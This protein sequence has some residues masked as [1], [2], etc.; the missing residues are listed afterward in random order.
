MTPYP[1]GTEAFRQHIGFGDGAN[2][3][4]FSRFR[5]SNPVSL[6]NSQSQYDD[7]TTDMW[8]HATTT[9]GATVHLPDQ[10][11]VRLSTDTTPGASVIRQTQRYVRYQPGKSQLV[12]VTFDNEAVDGGTKRA[13]Y[14]DGENGIFIEMDATGGISFNRRS[15][16]T[17]SVVTDSVSQADWNVDGFGHANNDKNPSGIT[18]SNIKSQIFIIDLQWLAVGRVRV[19]VDI[20]G[21]VLYGH[22]FNWAN[23]NNGVYMTTANLPIRYELIGNGNNTTFMAICCSVSSEGGFVADLGHEHVTPNGTTGV[24][25]GT[26]S[27]TFLLAIRPK[28]LVNSI[29][30][31]GEYVPEGISFYTTNNACIYRLW[32]GG[33][34]TGGAW[35]SSDDESGLEYNVGATISTAGHLTNSDF[36]AAAGGGKAFSTAGRGQASNR[37]FLNLDIDGTQP[38]HSNFYVTGQGLGGTASAFCNIHWTEIK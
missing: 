25:C 22:N 34:L 8:N 17:G 6:L 13:G 10:S 30:N 5:V 24:S 2:F 15:K 27:D 11:S 20:D 12:F 19:G 23:E 18:L 9:G 31:R 38:D 3:D 33:T 36:G 37:I 16:A 4:A 26:G 7:G 35:A 28:L 29:T 21:K 1:D 32:H 14:F